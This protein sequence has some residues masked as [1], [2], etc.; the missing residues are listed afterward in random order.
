MKR[1][2]LFIIILALIVVATAGCSLSNIS[3]NN[4][5]TIKIGALLPLTGGAAIYGDS[6][7]KAAEIA[8]EEINAKGGINGHKIEI[9]YQDHQC[10]PQAAISAFQQLS[11]VNGLKLFSSVACSGTVLGI[12][13]LLKSDQILIATVVSSVKVTG[14]SPSVFRNYASD[15][16]GARL[17]G[18]YIVN[19]NLRKIAIIYEET[20]YAKGMKLMLEKNLENKEVKIVSEGFTTDATD[21]RTPLL[22]LKNA[23]PDV[24][25]MSVQSPTS[26]DKVLKEAKEINFRPKT[27]LVNEAIMHSADLNSKYKNYLDGAISTDFAIENIVSV[28]N[29]LDT[30]KEKYG[31]DCPQQNAC[32]GMYDDIYILAEAAGKNNMDMSQAVESLKNINYSGAGGEISFDKNNDRKN[33]HFILYQIKNSE[34]I[35]Y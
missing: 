27:L 28:K 1:K 8:V 2:S 13:P 18:E 26:G 10:A 14:V 20:D 5:E 19:N 21:V 31:A 4:K 30:Y 15:A 7:Q 34:I 9:N 17:F 24:L 22:K 32:I 23:N 11:N 33:A 6:A 25:L 3:K 16:D 12:A 35:P 29:L